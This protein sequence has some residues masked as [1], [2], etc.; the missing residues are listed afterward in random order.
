[1]QSVDSDFRLFW[2]ELEQ[3]AITLGFE[4]N[5]ESEKETRPPSFLT[6][7][8]YQSLFDVHFN[9][10]WFGFLEEFSTTLRWYAYAREYRQETLNTLTA[11]VMIK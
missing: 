11:N 10:Y 7:D 9:E 1:M 5:R 6:P 8:M 2:I 4:G 3:S